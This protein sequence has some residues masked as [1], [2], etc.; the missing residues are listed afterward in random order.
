MTPE[1]LGRI[2]EALGITLPE[3][4]RRRLVPIPIPAA[5]NN[6]DLGV[7]DR[8]DALIEYNRSLRAGDIGAA[9]PPR[10]FAIGHAGDGCPTALDLDDGSVWWVHHGHLDHDATGK[11]A[12]DFDTWADDYFATL[13]DEMAGEEVDPDGTPAARERMERRNAS[14]TALGCTVV[15]VVVATIVVGIRWWLR[16]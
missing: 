10:M 16:H 14:Q 8:A 9:W 13:R 1:D 3:A 12:K 5:A 4:Y 7:W 11:V 2:E 6:G 15:L